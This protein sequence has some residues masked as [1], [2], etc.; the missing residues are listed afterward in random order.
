[1]K[2]I[3]KSNGYIFAPIE[4][5][6]VELSK[7]AAAPIDWDYFRYPFPDFNFGAMCLLCLFVWLMKWRSNMFYTM[8]ISITKL[9]ISLIIFLADSI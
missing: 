7:I 2:L 1:M 9:D 4:G 5:S 6:V 3:D 8:Q